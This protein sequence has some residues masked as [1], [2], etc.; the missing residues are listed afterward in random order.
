MKQIKKVFAVLLTVILVF[1]ASGVYAQPLFNA[2][3]ILS[4]NFKKAG[5]VVL[6]YNESFDVTL[7]LKTGENYFAGPFS[8]Q[9]F[10]TN[11]ILKNGSAEFNK[12]GKLYSVSKSFSN[13]SPSS[14]MTNNG[15][16]RF[17]PKDWNATQ[18]SKYDFYNIT[19]IPNTTDAAVSVDN[20]NE[21]I[22]TISLTSGTNTG[23]GAVFVSASSLKSTSNATG[24]TYL[25]CLTDNGKISSARYDFGADASL[26]LTNASLSVIV[27]DAGDV[28]GNQ[29]LNS[30]DALLILQHITELKT[31]TG[32]QLK[33]C[34]TNNDGTTNSAD[35]LGVLQ[36]STGLVRLND[37]Y[38]Q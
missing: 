32:N 4:S 38:K 18:C 28:D 22:I 16:K 6:S 26:D 1:T 36:V 15:A 9:V 35:A 10:Y 12:S 21:K 29:K 2:S 14:M 11:S 17:Y 23:S 24:E 13:A 8:A 34:D 20:L 25:S 27:S 37:I 7:S 30:S 19:M 33:R 5:A 31:L 3:V